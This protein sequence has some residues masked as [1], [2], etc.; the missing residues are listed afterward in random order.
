MKRIKVILI[1]PAWSQ[2]VCIPRINLGLA[3]V[4]SSLE[5]NGYEVEILD[6]MVERLSSEEVCERIQQISAEIIGF[7]CNTV[8]Y[9]FVEETLKHLLNVKRKKRIKII[10]GG[11]HARIRPM[12][13]MN[14]PGVDFVIKGE[15]ENTI[16]ELLQYIDDASKYRDV[17]GIFYRD[18]KDQ[19]IETPDRPFLENL[20]ELP[21]PSRRLFPKPH[22]LNSVGIYETTIQAT[23]GCPFDC[24]YCAS[25]KLWKRKVRFR[26]TK[27]VVDEME[28]ILKE[29]P[30][31]KSFEFV[32]DTF[33]LKKEYVMSL[34][35]EMLKRKLKVK[36]QAETRA[37][38][39]TADTISKMKRA[40]LY[41]IQIG[42]E[43]GNREV[44]RKAKKKID[45][46][47]VK[48]AVRLVKSN[49]VY[50]E[51]LCQVGLP[52]E[53]KETAGQ[54]IK[55]AQG[56]SPDSV[57]FQLTT[58]FP[59]SELCEQATRWGRVTTYNY[60]EYLTILPPKFIPQ[61]MTE[62]ELIEMKHYADKVAR[63]IEVNFAKRTRFIRYKNRIK[64]IRSWKEA[65]EI[66]LKALRLARSL[67]FQI[68]HNF[69]PQ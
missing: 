56:L 44:L 65:K 60:N 14:L 64:Q 55:F 24:V 29:F 54:T 52:G 47:Q 16:V 42:L 3:Y 46:E 17:R 21:F 62:K 7:T 38:F 30:D 66:L 37:D 67:V 51:L 5:S 27:N 25:P 9:G 53:T 68:I 4:A 36:F 48:R 61:D 33:T 11:V 8:Q 19:I 1:N 49:R 69:N 43:S 59:G 12:E 15:G 41:W 45:L 35:D 20:D 6:Q 39:L 22:W 40:G 26:S 57:C 10:V 34:C 32:D 58:P 28:E 31:I 2:E 50:V 18:E 13:C 23:R 63:E